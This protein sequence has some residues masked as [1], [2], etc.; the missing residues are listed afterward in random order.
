LT[1]ENDLNFKV[2]KGESITNIELVNHYRLVYDA[3]TGSGGVRSG[4]Y[5]V[6]HARESDF[7]DRVGYSFYLNF[8]KPIVEALVLPCFQ[9]PPERINISKT[10]E[11]DVFEQ[12]CDGKGNSLNIFMRNTALVAKRDG[13]VFVVMDNF[14]T[15]PSNQGEA[16]A[17]RILPY[18]YIKKA[19]D[20]VY[21]KSDKFGNL[22]E[23]AFLEPAGEK[24]KNGEEKFN[25][26]LW[27]NE[28]WT[29]YSGFNAQKEEFEGLIE[30]DTIKTGKM[31]IVPIY[32]TDADSS[33]VLPVPPLYDIARINIA[34]YNIWS[35][36][37]E[38]M[39]KITFPILAL[40]SKGALAGTDIELG[41]GNILGFPWDSPREP[42]FL[43]P[44]TAIIQIYI[45]TANNLREEAYR[46]AKINGVTGVLESSGKAKEWD[47]QATKT[48]LSNL[49]NT[50]QD[51][52]L[53]LVDIFAKWIQK[54]V[55]V[56][57]SYA[58]DFGVSDLKGDIDRAEVLLGLGLPVEVSKEIKKDLISGLFNRKTPE[59]RAEMLDYIE[60]QTET[61]IRS[62]DNN[63]D[64]ESDN[65]TI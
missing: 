40:P 60:K 9:K 42:K 25:I 33:E 54:Q 18:V 49:S 59:E 11:Y 15:V 29:L 47:F 37:R 45:D 63:T 14:S 26:R 17:N 61:E 46:Q 28:S 55:N 53:K 38:I 1:L 56:S 34:I 41:A 5:L 57:I 13:V 39:R 52:E 16:L 8:F 32:T 21:Y 12:N 62:K 3:F 19:S 27:T 4:A 50:L 24:T 64:N 7:T 10:K 65:T 20:C 43:Q 44:E 51:A 2:A 36:A 31:P 58:L 30:T 6:K 22:L 35:E 23:I 48:E